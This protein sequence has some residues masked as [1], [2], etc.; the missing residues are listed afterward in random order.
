MMYRRFE[1]WRKLDNVYGV[2]WTAEEE[3]KI[4]EQ[5]KV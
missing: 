5:V 3:E 1:G 4:Y 2:T